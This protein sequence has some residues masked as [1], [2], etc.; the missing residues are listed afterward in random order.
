MI[1][2]RNPLSPERLTN[3]AKLVALLK[4]PVARHS[5]TPEGHWLAGSFGTRR[6]VRTIS[7]NLRASAGW[8]GN[9]LA[10]QLKTAS[11]GR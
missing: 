7:G 1:G 3:T 6:Q 10:E 11:Q 9:R 4:R 5:A 8:C 2:G